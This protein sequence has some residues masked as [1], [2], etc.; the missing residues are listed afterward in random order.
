MEHAHDLGPGTS[1]FAFGSEAS[2]RYPLSVEYG[3]TSFYSAECDTHMGALRC[4]TVMTLY[5]TTYSMVQGLSLLA[6]H[7][8]KRM[9]ILILDP[10]SPARLEASRV[11][12]E[13]PLG[14]LRDWLAS[15][16]HLLWL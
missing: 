4:D 10:A 14:S 9:R 8:Y 5:L 11:P 16:T 1:D 13:V 7:A 6:R 12:L 2:K 15:V 3:T